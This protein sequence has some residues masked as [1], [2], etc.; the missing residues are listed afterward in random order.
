M[1]TRTK[2]ILRLFY[3]DIY[4]YVPYKLEVFYILVL[5]IISVIGSSNLVFYID[6][7]NRQTI[8]NNNN[9]I[10][11]M[12]FTIWSMIFVTFYTCIFYSVIA[13]ILFLRSINKN[14]SYYDQKY[15][16]IYEKTHGNTGQSI[17]MYFIVPFED[18][19]VKSYELKWHVFQIL[20]WSIILSKAIYSIYSCIYYEYRLIIII[21]DLP[22]LWCSI[23]KIYENYYTWYIKTQKYIAKI[24][25]DIP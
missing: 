12:I 21:T 10:I 20:L 24:I 25:D 15:L 23:V 18:N 2:K 13:D 17:F 7:F 14:V 4:A 9:A 1:N 16:H 8:E 19:C 6:L 3:N 22:Y 5:I 11:N